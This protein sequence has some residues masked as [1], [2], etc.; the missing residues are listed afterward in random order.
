MCLLAGI[1]AAPVLSKETK[2]DLYQRV[3]T[4]TRRIKLKFST[5]QDEIWKSI[6]DIQGLVQL[7]LGMGMLSKDDEEH[8]R[9]NPSNVSII[10]TKYWS[11][12]DFEN[13]EH[14]V[15]R[16]CSSVEKRMMEEYKEEVQMFCQR[17]VSEL[18]PNS[19]DSSGNITG[20]RKLCVLLDLDDPALQRVRHLKMAIAIILGCRTSDL[21]LQNIEPGSVLVTYLVNGTLGEKLFER[22]MTAKQK[23]SLKENNVTW[24][25]YDDRITIFSEA[26]D[27]SSG[28]IGMC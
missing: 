12:L 1:P 24:I 10:L 18:P 7:V 15:E 25:R 11:F 22:R 14:I 26:F 2:E 28:Q 27:S 23:T 9:K 19:L 4:D 8:I 16:K 6:N 20:M 21:V 3:I 17:R 5:L 13:L